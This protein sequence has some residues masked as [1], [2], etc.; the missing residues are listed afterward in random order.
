MMINITLIIQIVNFLI[1]YTF[2]RFLFFKPAYTVI[3]IEQ[4]EQD[5]FHNILVQQNAII[6]RKELELQERWCECQ[7]YFLRNTPPVKMVELF[8]FKHI[9]PSVEKPVSL[10]PQM[11]NELVDNIQ[12][13]LIE[14]V[15]K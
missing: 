10:A 15:N 5:A 4:Q 12:K 3:K 9:T 2:L 7:E 6:A 1:A 8:V 14:K 13:I 11:I